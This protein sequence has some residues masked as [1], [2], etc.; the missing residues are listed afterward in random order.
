MKILI[1]L[2][3][4]V[5]RGPVPQCIAIQAHQPDAVH[6]IQTLYPGQQAN[7]HQFEYTQA[8]LEKSLLSKYNLDDPYPV[9]VSAP[10]GYICN[11]EV[12]P[13]LHFHQ[14]NMDGLVPKINE[15]SELFSQDTVCFDLLPGGKE[16]KLQSLFA[17]NKNLN[18]TYSTE[19]GK[20]ID[21]SS[22]LTE[23]GSS[24]PLSLVDR[25][26]LSGEP[27]YVEKSH[28][29]IEDDST[30][31]TAIYD[32]L[33]VELLTERKKEELIA[34]RTNSKKQGKIG[35]SDIFDRP[36]STFNQ[37]FRTNFEC[38]GVMLQHPNA[39]SDDVIFEFDD[40][41]IES[42]PEKKE[43]HPNG[44]VLEPVIT[45][46]LNKHWDVHDSLTGVSVIYP[47]PEDRLESYRNIT[48]KA[49]D[50]I[51]LHEKVNQFALRCE[52][53]SLEWK[54]TTVERLMEVEFDAIRSGIL[55]FDE[56]LKFIRQVEL[57]T[58]C[59]VDSGVL[60]F[61]TKAFISKLDDGKMK[62]KAMQKPSSLFNNRS[63]GQYY[64]VCSTSPDQTLNH[65]PVIHMTQLLNGPH[66]LNRHNKHQWMP[67]KST[68]EHLQAQCSDELGALLN[69]EEV[70]DPHEIFAVVSKAVGVRPGVLARLLFG[71]RDASALRTLE[72]LV[73]SD[74]ELKSQLWEHLRMYSSNL[75]ER[76]EDSLKNA[77]LKRKIKEQVAKI[78][79]RRK[80]IE[81]RKIPHKD[82][83]RKKKR[84]RKEVHESLLEIERNNEDH[85][86]EYKEMKL[87]LS[88]LDGEITKIKAKRQSIL[89]EKEQEL[90][91][92]K[93][94]SIEIELPPLPQDEML[95]SVVEDHLKN[96]N[97]KSS[98]LSALIDQYSELHEILHDGK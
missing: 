13:T 14:V 42:F 6:F 43:G 95:G 84:E 36:L 24:I 56:A 51:H 70:L 44:T 52:R 57:D 37:G 31:L 26:W 87:K 64:V 18:L 1:V 27:V 22:G 78:K 86:L 80:E 72:V 35:D 85:T 58:I 49:Y 53:V 74:A 76:I 48:Q 30:F 50:A 59:L 79:K 33:S 39:E 69:N 97:A 46:L 21:L 62:Q 45:N 20:I 60:S 73:R 9:P 65:Q 89:A 4:P 7:K 61:D 12:I 75:V 3:P 28:A 93:T 83:L 5:V 41:R 2:S 55:S 91:N 15:L 25:F 23:E 10:V 40:G 34:R 71:D 54:T 81:N 82:V 67:T 94:D 63:S 47:R 68:I 38:E 77:I 88:D 16:A 92:L 8:W 98:V 29:A 19:N 96:H 32:A 17:E 11:E 90:R 66:I